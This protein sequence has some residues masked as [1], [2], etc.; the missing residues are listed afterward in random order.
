[1]LIGVLSYYIEVTE[2]VLLW[3]SAIESWMCW[4]MEDSSENSVCAQN[5]EKGEWQRGR[6]REQEIGTM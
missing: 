5:K 3:S 6:E 1:M 4:Q 2:R